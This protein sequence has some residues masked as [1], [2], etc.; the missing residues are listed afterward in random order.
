MVSGYGDFIF[1]DDFEAVMAILDEDE[2]VDEQFHR[3]LVL[4]FTK[5][6]GAIVQF[7]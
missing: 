6:S 2:S 7:V 4:K 1:E 5:Y 3:R